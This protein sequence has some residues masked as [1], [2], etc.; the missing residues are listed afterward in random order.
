MSN[1]TIRELAEAL[2]DI[3]VYVQEQA[4]ENN[5]DWALLAKNQVLVNAMKALTTNAEAIKQARGEDEVV[6]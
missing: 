4:E 1:K 3:K 2:E 5:L 6:S